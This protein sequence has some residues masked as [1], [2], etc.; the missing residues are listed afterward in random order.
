MDLNIVILVGSL[1][2]PVVLRTFES[3]ASRLELSVAVRSDVPGRRVDIV[4]VVKWNPEDDLLDGWLVPGRR[5][6]VVGSI[7]RPSKGTSGDGDRRRIQIL[8]GNITRRR[9][10]DELLA[11]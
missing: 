1:A 10:D 5:V 7:R 2:A 3:G 11:G 9:P 4:P 6:W 8:A